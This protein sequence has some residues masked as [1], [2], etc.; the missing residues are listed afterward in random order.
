MGNVQSNDTVIFI[1]GTTG[2]GKSKLAMDLACRMNGEI[3][4]AD[5]M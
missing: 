2:V 1:V 5:S 4:N 3:I